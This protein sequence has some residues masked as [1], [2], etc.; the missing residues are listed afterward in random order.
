MRL[1]GPVKKA[2]V[3]ATAGTAGEP[4]A[5]CKLGCFQTYVG[6]GLIE[7]PTWA[8]SVENRLVGTTCRGIGLAAY[9]SLLG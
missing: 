7:R 4:P 5:A 8:G 9:K 1:L 6:D 3:L 2:D